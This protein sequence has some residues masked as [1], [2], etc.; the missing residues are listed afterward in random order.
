MYMALSFKYKCILCKYLSARL[1]RKSSTSVL[2]TGFVRIVNGTSIDRQKRGRSP[3]DTVKLTRD[4]KFVRVSPLFYFSVVQCPVNILPDYKKSSANELCK[5]SLLRMDLAGYMLMSIG[6]RYGKSG[7]RVVLRNARNSG[8]R[9]VLV[10][11]GFG[12]LQFGSRID[13][14]RNPCAISCWNCDALIIPDFTVD[15]VWSLKAYREVLFR[16]P[17]ERCLEDDCPSN[18][19][20]GRNL[21][22]KD[23]YLQLWLV[24]RRKGY[25]L[26]SASTST[27]Y[28]DLS[29]EL[30]YG[31]NS[32]H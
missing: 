1:Q 24:V 29:V 30:W 16:W 17:L 6:K 2:E 32:K 13:V 21:L 10:Q 14:E 26:Q 25:P 4:A 22:K 18:A 19:S 15:Y 11:R 3:A 12:F 7:C 9:I 5:S 20:K 28:S 8:T 23:L 31:D 27:L